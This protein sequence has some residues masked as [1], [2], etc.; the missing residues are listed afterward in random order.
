MSDDV[1]KPGKRIEDETT[2][3]ATPEEIF[4]AW[5][6]PEG[7]ERWF[8][9]ESRGSLE[10]GELVWGWPSYG[11]EHTLRVLEHER[12]RRLVLETVWGEGT[13]TVIEVT[14][15]PSGEGTRVRLVHSGFLDDGS[16]DGEYEGASSGWTN[17]LATLKLQLERY[18]GRSKRTIDQFQPAV[19]RLDDVLTATRTRAGSAAWLGESKDGLGAPGDPVSI[20]S[21][22]L[23][24]LTGKVIARTDWETTITW[25]EL[26]GAL[27]FQAFPGEA[28]IQ[29]GERMLGL[30]LVSWSE[31]R[32]AIERAG[33][34]LEVAL[35]ELVEHVSA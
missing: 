22:S 10:Q 11:F 33:M 24:T 5:T 34:G 23:G 30:R 20:E 13:P 4:E 27:T 18:P 16:W 6:T 21:E 25:A 2:I 12:G 19:Y 29:A 28:E 14:L 15:E 17:A 8:V 3:Q 7:L 31:D 9:D 26:E 1:H 32:E 35:S